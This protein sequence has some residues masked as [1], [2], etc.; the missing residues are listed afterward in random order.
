MKTD[1]STI[2]DPNVGVVRGDYNNINVTCEVRGSFNVVNAPGC[3]VRGDYNQINGP[4]CTVRGD[5]N[6]INSL[7]CTVKGDFT[8]WNNGQ[9]Q[10]TKNKK[11]TTTS[12]TQVFSGS[13]NQTPIVSSVGPSNFV[14]MNDN[15][16][17]S[18]GG[19]LRDLLCDKGS[20]VR[21]SGSSSSRGNIV[22]HGEIVVGDLN[23]KG[24]G[25]SLTANGDNQKVLAP[26]GGAVAVGG[27]TYTLLPSEEPAIFKDGKWVSGS[28]PLELIEDTT[29]TTTT[30]KPTTIIYSH[31]KSNNNSSER[32][33][34]KA[35][36]DEDAC[37]ICLETRKTVL[38]KD[39]Q[40]L[41]L[42]HYCALSEYDGK[43]IS[44]QRMCPICRTKITEL[45]RIVNA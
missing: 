5:F 14:I 12:N 41:V 8:Q 44:E 33:K 15:Y 4:N 17:G 38:I 11:T 40:H 42:C 30:N 39:C 13:F 18:S 10:P 45:Y 22:S 21:N 28:K 2:N 9:P 43:E 37:V 20:I 23:I 19:N 7:G 24:R 32:E 35:E 27:K 34:E 29:A 31:K 16:S 6:V 25:I 3:S 36:K 26:N 1:Y